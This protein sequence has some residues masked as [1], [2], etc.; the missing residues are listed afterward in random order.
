MSRQTQPTD[1]KPVRKMSLKMCS[2][3]H[4]TIRR[5]TLT[6]DPESEK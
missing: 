4:I 3:S 6:P 2:S 1:P 5:V